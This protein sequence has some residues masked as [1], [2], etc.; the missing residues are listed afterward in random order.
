MTRPFGQFSPPAKKFHL[1]CN[2]SR[3]HAELV[4]K[5]DLPWVI[6]CGSACWVTTHRRR[7]LSLQLPPGSLD[8]RAIGRSLTVPSNT[9]SDHSKGE[10]P[11]KKTKLT[12]MLA[13]MGGLTIATSAC[14]KGADNTAEAP[15]GAAMADQATA[16][17]SAKP[18]AAASCAAKPCAAKPCAAKGCAPKACGAKPC[19]AKPCAAKPCAAKH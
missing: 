17:C 19:A 10:N 16:S 2:Q 12:T 3:Q 15:A 13:V 8:L 7:F 4:T 14:S 11:M 5:G 6:L 1:S 9:R 18:C